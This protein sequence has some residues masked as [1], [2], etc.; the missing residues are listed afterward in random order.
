M[1]PAFIIFCIYA[2]AIT[3][4]ATQKLLIFPCC[5]R[6]KQIPLRVFVASIW[7]VALVLNSLVE[8]Y[9]IVRDSL[10][11]MMKKRREQVKENSAETKKVG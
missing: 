11:K 8:L 10:L 3:G 6:H 2:Y 4:Y 9:Y 1:I 5:E 7:P